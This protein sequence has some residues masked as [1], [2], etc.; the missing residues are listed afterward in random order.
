MDAQAVAEQT[1][2]RFPGRS[3]GRGNAARGRGAARRVGSAQRRDG[4]GGALAG[5]DLHPVYVGADKDVVA[6]LLESAENP[7]SRLF[8]FFA[9]WDASRGPWVRVP[10]PAPVDINSRLKTS[11]LA[12]CF[13]KAKALW[14]LAFSRSSISTSGPQ[15]FGHSRL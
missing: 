3:D 2:H 13:R 15:A 12:I 8:P 9:P 5:G 1:G 4:G 10:S 11:A 14:D 7:A 6:E